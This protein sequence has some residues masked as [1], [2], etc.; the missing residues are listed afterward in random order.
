MEEV[1][2]LK[3]VLE[4]VEGRLIAAGKMYGAMNFAVW[5]AIMLLYYVMLGI[6]DISWQFNLIYWPLGFAVAMVF[7]GRI[8]KRLKRLGRV[9]GREIESSPLAGILIGLSWATGIVLGWVIVPDL[10][11]G[12]TEEASLATGFLTF[13]AFSVF[14][15]WLVMAGFSPK[16]GEREII[17]AFLIPALGIL[18]S[19]GMAEGAIAWAGFVVGL[20]F[21]LTVLWYLYSAFK[22]IER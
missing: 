3:S 17:P 13:I 10:N 19:T 11:P 9:T 21:S 15:M 12:I 20:G 22:A 7:T 8:W 5:L 18:R 1:S 16:N 2:E 14:A 4:R 6:F